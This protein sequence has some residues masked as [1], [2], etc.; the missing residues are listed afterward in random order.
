MKLLDGALGV[1]GQA[2]AVRTRRLELIAQNI[3]NADTP[4]FKSRDLDFRT[5]LAEAGTQPTSM[6]AT[7][8]GHYEDGEVPELNG[9]RYRVP[10]N[11]SVDGNTVEISVE[12]AQYGKA[13]AQYQTTLSFLE[14]R[15]SGLR[16]ALR[17][18]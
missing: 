13:A 8:E 1:H 9:L 12:Q 7:R 4:N 14:N 10:F 15:I 3:A 17:G 5:V 18:E 6:K 11:T 2:L 16:K